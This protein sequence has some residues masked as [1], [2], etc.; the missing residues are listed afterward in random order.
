MIGAVK[1]SPLR[2]WQIALSQIISGITED[3]VPAQ[4]Q[5]IWYIRFPRT[6]LAV[7]VGAIYDYHYQRIV[8]SCNVDR[9]KR[10]TFTTY[11]KSEITCQARRFVLKNIQ[12]GHMN[13]L[14][15]LGFISLYV[16]T[17]VQR[18]KERLMRLVVQNTVMRVTVTR[19]SV[20][21]INSRLSKFNEI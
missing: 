10:N 21:V 11:S 15:V 9:F 20:Y 6:L 2:V 13:V 8:S 17:A 16:S 1:I 4:V 19:G 12:L 18:W 5:I 3:W 7:L 14:S